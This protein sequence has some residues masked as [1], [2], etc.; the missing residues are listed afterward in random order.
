MR[1]IDKT[2]RWDHNKT[3]TGKKKNYKVTVCH[4]AHPLAGKSFWYFLL[5]KDDYRYNSLWDDL[6][7]VSQD[8]CVEA[9]E[10]KI[11]ELTKGACGNQPNKVGA[12]VSNR[13]QSWDLS[14]RKDTC[15]Y[16]I[17]GLCGKGVS[18]TGSCKT[19]CSFFESQT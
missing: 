11:N 1:L 3:L 4:S 16:M 6:R 12:K 9:V 7:Y 8:Q 18:S 15:K 19:P 2:K 5:D 10:D 13:C 14:L 17:N